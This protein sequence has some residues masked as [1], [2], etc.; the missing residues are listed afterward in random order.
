MKTATAT[1]TYIVP[2]AML[3]EN[4]HRD[5]PLSSPGIKKKTENGMCRIQFY[6]AEGVHMAQCMM[7]APSLPG[8]P[9]QTKARK[10]KKNIKKRRG[11][12]AASVKLFASQE[13]KNPRLA[14]LQPR[15]QALKLVSWG[16]CRIRPVI[17]DGSGRR[18]TH[19]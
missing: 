7:Y 19:A 2:R 1:I 10:E 17:G 13:K 6:R 15:K 18:N 11:G 4:Q 9:F 5:P 14:S 16:A 12:G 8:Y 3:N